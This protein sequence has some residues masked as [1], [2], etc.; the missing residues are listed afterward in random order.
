LRAID[1]R[2]VA[3]SEGVYRLNGHKWFCS[4]P[5]SDAFLTLARTD[6]GVTCFFVPRS[7]PDGTRNCLRINRLKDKSGNRSNAS[8]EIEYQ[9]ALALRVGEEGKGIATLIEMAHLTR[10][11]I[12]VAA[13]GMMRGML[14]Q[15]L[16]Y[17]AHRSAFGKR[18]VEQAL[19]Q[20]VLADLCIETE[21]ATLLAFR[22]AQAFDR[23]EADPRERLITRI[24]TPVAK[25]WL[26]KRN[27]MFM[28][29]VMECAGGNGFTEDWPFARFY[30]EATV[31]SIWEGSGNVICLDA[32]R[33]MRKEP[34]SLVAL[35]ADLQPA[36]D[37]DPRLEAW[38]QIL[39]REAADLARVESRARFVVEGLALAT[40]AA[41]LMQ[42]AP[43]PVADVFCATRLGAA[44]GRAFGTLPA[45]TDYA[46]IIA[47]A[48]PVFG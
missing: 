47:R 11:D 10:F 16:H 33:A 12:V 37:T 28:A 36:A 5:M 31:N 39:R 32:L 22:L 9:D 1:T 34:E 29:E 35:L 2:A 20:N 7:V 27:P 3:T 30:R 8:A 45:N 38:L 44:G 40:Q 48:W 14:T 18:L 15:V 41:L 6:T 19:M 24:L 25:Y 26:A 42:Y 13:A 4:V 23:A 17:C 43:P 46:R 21:A